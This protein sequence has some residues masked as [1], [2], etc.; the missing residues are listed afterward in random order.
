[1]NK[2]ITL[3]F[4]GSIAIL[5]I[6]L[7]LQGIH[8]QTF[9]TDFWEISHIG[10]Y[11]QHVEAND[12]YIFTVQTDNAIA[13]YTII[14]E[15]LSLTKRTYNLSNSIFDFT[16]SN[17]YVA[18]VTIDREIKVFSA[19]TLTLLYTYSDLERVS[20][21]KFGGDL[22]FVSNLSEI[23]ILDTQTGKR[24]GQFSLSGDQLFSWAYADHSLYFLSI[25]GLVA[26][27]LVELDLNDPTNP[28]IVHDVDEQMFGE[29]LVYDNLLFVY[30]KGGNSG[31]PV[32]S[33]RELSSNVFI[34][35]R[36]PTLRKIG[37]F[38]GSALQDIAIASSDRAYIIGNG[39]LTELDISMPSQP[40][41][42]RRTTISTQT[43]RVITLDDALF[44]AQTNDTPFAGRG[45]DTIERYNLADLTREWQ[46]QLHAYATANV[47]FA[48]N[49]SLL[50]SDTGSLTAYDVSDVPKMRH[51]SSIPVAL[52]SPI[53]LFENQYAILGYEGV[54]NV[55]Q[56]DNQNPP[57]LI[58]TNQIETADGWGLRESVIVDD[59]LHIR[60]GGVVSTFDLTVPFTPTHHTNTALSA[61]NFGSLTASDSHLF[62]DIETDNAANLVHIYSAE[63]TPQFVSEESVGTD[64]IIADLLYADEMLFVSTANSD[65]LV[66]DVASWTQIDVIDN[67]PAYAELRL[68]ADK[69]RLILFGEDRIILLDVSSL[70]ELANYNVGAGRGLQDVALHKSTLALT[71]A[72]GIFI[73]RYRGDFP[74]QNYLPIIY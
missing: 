22:L 21:V 71:T 6:G 3:L 28:I 34:Y 65:V 32:P 41:I 47:V 25:A 43:F 4:V 60:N 15:A 56:F 54:L 55:T 1:M 48:E 17:E 66:Y 52:T 68:S 12:N 49:G 24:L 8:A 39:F 44:L 27:K 13:Q 9:P 64:V 53:R 37:Q 10:G 74:Q 19:D 70:E 7:K 26:P 72:D 63:A 50:V 51:E 67:A 73:L 18:V 40:Q 35:E 11:L 61:T 23:D 29:V 42:A 14:N 31:Y 62:I 5:F 45:N 58:R 33:S 69:T 59:Y 38:S 57:T 30:E 16:V 2:S 20:Q 36:K 46:F